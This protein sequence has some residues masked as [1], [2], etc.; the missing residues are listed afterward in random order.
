LQS[1]QFWD[2]TL[3]LIRSSPVQ[4][5]ERMLFLRQINGRKEAFRTLSPVG[6]GFHKKV[7]EDA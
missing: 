7:F 3:S 2:S 4:A 1:A 6:A 5:R